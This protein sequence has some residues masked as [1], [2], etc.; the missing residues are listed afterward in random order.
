M[1]TLQKEL[2]QKEQ[3]K[4]ASRMKIDDANDQQLALQNDLAQI[5]QS[6]HEVSIK[7]SMLTR[8]KERLELHMARKE[9]K[10]KKIS[11]VL[12]SKPS[13]EL[14]SEMVDE[15]SLSIIDLKED[16]LQIQSDIL[17]QTAKEEQLKQELS[18]KEKEAEESRQALVELK[19]KQERFSSAIDYQREAIAE[20]VRQAENQQAEVHH[21]LQDIHL[22]LQPLTKKSAHLAEEKEQLEKEITKKE[23]L[24]QELM[25]HRSLMGDSEIFDKL[26]AEIHAS[27]DTNRNC[28]A[29]I[30]EKIAKQMAKQELLE[31]KV[32]KKKRAVK[33]ND[34]LLHELK[35]QHSVICSTLEAKRKIFDCQL[36]RK[37]QPKEKLQE[38]CKVSAFIETAY[39]PFQ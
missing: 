6:L 29:H 12:T 4:T 35:Q 17:K 37:H 34:Q 7:S 32:V 8:K 21:I 11:T 13:K 18:K 9:I 27:I 39:T 23:K 25:P 33:E 36:R 1:S 31:Q 24:Q 26:K 10:Q 15:V 16:L 5:C 30:G 14:V 38:E 28:L 20:D 22:S 3:Q 2:F 19:V